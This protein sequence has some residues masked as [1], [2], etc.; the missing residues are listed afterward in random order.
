MC[1]C[2]Y[3]CACWCMCRSHCSQ[4]FHY[5]IPPSSS[6]KKTLPYPQGASVVF[7]SFIGFDTVATAAEEVK[8]PGRDLPIGIVGSLSICTVLYV[9]MCLVITGM[10]KFTTIDLDAPFAVA[11]SKVGMGW[12]QRVVAAGALTGIITSLLGSLLGQARIYVTL[13]RQALAPAWLARVHPVRG[14]P[15][16]ATIVT[17]FTAGFLALFIEIELLAEL[18]S[19][20]TLVVFCS[21]CSGVLFRRYHVHGSGESLQPLAWRLGCV[22]L[23]SVGFSV[24]YTEKAHISVPFIFLGL[25]LIVTASFLMLPVRY[26]PQVFRCPGSPFIP[27]LGMLATLHLIGSLGWPAYVRWIVWFILG[28]IVYLSYG[29]HKAQRRRSGSDLGSRIRT[30]AIVHKAR[31]KP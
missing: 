13:G 30:A 12:A 1:M 21:V 9:A 22:V 26:T 20:G 15:V 16:N 18:V 4:Y 17:M 3:V 14:T 31:G 5:P 11:F 29:V 24:S 8:N 25:W 10:E 23:F 27:S 28:T 19:I 6:S 2:V 7:F